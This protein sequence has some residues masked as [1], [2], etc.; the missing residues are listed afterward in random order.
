MPSRTIRTTQKVFARIGICLLGTTAFMLPP[1]TPAYAEPGLPVIIRGIPGSPSSTELQLAYQASFPN[2]SLDSSV[3]KLNVGPMQAG[4]TGIA[5]SNPTIEKRPGEIFISITRPVNLSPDL[6][7][8]MGVWATPVDFGPGSVSRIS[9]TYRAPVGPLPGGGFAIGIN[10][11]TGNKDDLTTDTRIAVTINV[12]PGFLVRLS[13]PFGATQ[14]TA[15]VLPQDVKDAMFSTTDPV[16]FTLELTMDRVEGTGTAKLTVGDQVF[17]LP[18]VL[19]AFR[20]D[21]GPS[22]TAVGPGLAVNPNAPG[23]TA[24]VHVRDFRIYTNV[25]K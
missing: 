15:M 6:I 5:G 1:A 16:P 17:S 4:D 22:I 23:Q 10:A 2:G 11:K 24:S 18:F 12:R 19:A 7:P 8:A 25:G 9:A 3:D 21:G 13:V 14:Q 20:A